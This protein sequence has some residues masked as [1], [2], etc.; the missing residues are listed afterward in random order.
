MAQRRHERAEAGQRVS[1][2]SLRRERYA[3]G[4]RYFPGLP[5]LLP[6]LL[7]CL[8]AMAALIRALILDESNLPQAIP[9]LQEA[10]ARQVPDAVTVEALR[11]CVNRGCPLAE[12]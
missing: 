6:I 3:A 11:R 1:S 10:L 9:T 7:F 8:P 5:L 4:E 2:R 12:D